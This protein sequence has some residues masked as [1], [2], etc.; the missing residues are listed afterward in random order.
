M[1]QLRLKEVEAIKTA[2]N[3]IQEIALNED[4]VDYPESGWRYIRHIMSMKMPIL[5]KQAI[6]TVLLSGTFN[7]D[8]GFMMPSTSACCQNFKNVKKRMANKRG[9]YMFVYDPFDKRADI[10][11]YFSVNVF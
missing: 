1:T 6:M 5:W 3:A 9:L 4:W 11:G 10:D 8:G 2:K 7:A